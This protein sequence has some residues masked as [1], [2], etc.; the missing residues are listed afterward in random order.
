MPYSFF[1]DSVDET[2]KQEEGSYV[3]EYVTQGLDAVEKVENAV[4]EGNPML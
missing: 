1:G 2:P 4:K 3:V